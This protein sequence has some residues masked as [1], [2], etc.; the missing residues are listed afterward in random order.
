MIVS[1]STTADTRE[2]TSHHVPDPID[3]LCALEE[4]RS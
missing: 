1:E 2:V 4:I 3:K